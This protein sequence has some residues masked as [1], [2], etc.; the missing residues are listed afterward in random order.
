MTR[1]PRFPVGLERLHKDKGARPASQEVLRPQRPLQH[2]A[3]AAA[4]QAAGHGAPQGI[5]M[6]SV[7]VRERMVQRL[8]ADGLRHEA[9]L[10]AFLRVERHH[11]VD[12][13]LAAQAYEDTSLPI[14]LSQTISKPS[15][16]GPSTISASCRST[17][18][19]T[20][21]GRTALWRGR[22][23]PATTRGRCAPA[24][25]RYNCTIRLI[26]SG[27]RRAWT[28]SCSS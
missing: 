2:A 17:P 12:S 13:A 19:G 3:E 16:R 5:G 1:S 15:V 8:R 22:W 9:V 11:F 18:C 23:Q 24:R 27:S 14:G 7:A 25:C 6:D 20:G 4:R 10:E 28:G 21:S 26:W